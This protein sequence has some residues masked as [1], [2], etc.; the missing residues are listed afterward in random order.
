M[1]RGNWTPVSTPAMKIKDKPPL[2]GRSR[3]PKSLS[4]VQLFKSTVILHQIESSLTIGSTSE[5][6]H[7]HIFSPFLT[8]NRACVTFTVTWSS[9]GRVISHLNKQTVFLPRLRQ[10]G[11]K[12]QALWPAA[13]SSPA[14]VN[15]VQ[16]CKHQHKHSQHSP[17]TNST[18][19]GLDL[20]FHYN[21]VI[22]LPF[23]MDFC[24]VRTGVSPLKPCWYGK[25]C[26]VSL[27]LLNPCLES[28]EFSQEVPTYLCGDREIIPG[29][30][31]KI[32]KLKTVKWLW[33][34]I[35]CNRCHNCSIENL[36]KL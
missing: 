11:W 35:A 32:G 27:F 23:P 8:G 33:G 19:E 2:P 6:I 14:G 9:E 30:I 10:M 3:C 36:Q 12:R 17:D 22:I 16:T 28:A 21:Q 7:R 18:S 26:S 5:T 15:K 25:G 13:C 4:L 31:C 24:V 34:T 29:S 20:S 1:H